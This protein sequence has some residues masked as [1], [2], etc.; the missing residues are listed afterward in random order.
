MYKYKPIKSSF[1]SV[2]KSEFFL[3]F[4]AVKIDVIGLITQEEK[5][6][7]EERKKKRE[8][9]RKEKE[10]KKKRNETKK[11]TFIRRNSKLQK[12]LFLEKKNVENNIEIIREHLTLV[13]VKG[14]CARDTTTLS[15][16]MITILYEKICK[17]IS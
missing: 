14:L 13:R 10:K 8:E 12:L 6:C 3:A 5:T 1:V 2:K 11:Q 7:M 15:K 17:Q 9:K 16:N 4:V